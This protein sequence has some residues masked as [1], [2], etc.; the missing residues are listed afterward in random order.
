MNQGE[1]TIKGF[2]PDRRNYSKDV[3]SVAGSDV[4]A[5]ALQ[6]SGAHR[7]FYVMAVGEIES[8]Q[9]C[10]CALSLALPL[11]LPPRCCA[12]AT[13]MPR[14]PSLFRCLRLRSRRRRQFPGRDRLW[15]NYNFVYGDDWHILQG[16]NNGSSQTSIKSGGEDA[17]AVWNFPLEVTF[18]STNASGWPRLVVSVRGAYRV[19]LLRARSAPCALS[20]LLP[21]P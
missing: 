12:A 13:L 2:P 8:G 5:G 10:R 1:K 18:K 4:G 11:Q 6:P 17:L 15:C 21:Q 20:A 16:V 3:M 7:G 9:V 19:V 14:H